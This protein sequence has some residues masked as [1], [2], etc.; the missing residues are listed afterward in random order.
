MDISIV[1]PVFNS[2]KI[3]PVLVERIKSSVGPIISGYEIIL[4][5]D[6]SSDNSWEVI[7]ILGKSNSSIKSLRLRKNVGQHNAIMAGL[8][9]CSG[10]VIVVMDDDLQ[11][12]PEEIPALYKKISQGYDVCFGAFRFRRHSWWKKLGSAFNNFGAQIILKKPKGLYLSPFKSFSHS[13]CTEIIRYKGQFTYLD[14]LI[15]MTTSNITMVTVEHHNRYEGYSNYGLYKSISLWAKMLTS[16][17]VLPLRLATILGFLVG[18]AGFGLAAISIGLKLFT[19]IAIPIGWTSLITIVLIISGVQLLALGVI[20]EYLGRTYL[21][22]NA[23][24]QYSVVEKVN[25]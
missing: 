7:Q 22:L 17:S 1:I 4:V 20:G 6:Q 12:P 18:L 2:A 11:H 16:F 25:L 15:L 8:N 21:S 9:A 13:I 10:H 14:G 5:D 23:V 19:T 3:L 24:S